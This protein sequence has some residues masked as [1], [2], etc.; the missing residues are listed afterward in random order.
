MLTGGANREIL[1]GYEGKLKTRQN[2]TNNAITK[3]A[4]AG[5]PVHKGSAFIGENTRRCRCRR[6]PMI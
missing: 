6:E 3:M 2:M 5:V 4:K 1:I